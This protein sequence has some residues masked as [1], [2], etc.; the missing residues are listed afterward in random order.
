MAAWSCG[1]VQKG[2]EEKRSIL[3]KKVEIPQHADIPFNSRLSCTW[4]SGLGG[5]SYSFTF[6]LVDFIG[7]GASLDCASSG[8]RVL[9]MQ[10][11]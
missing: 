3:V 2:E 4:F 1:L 9:C 7:F 6:G 10:V 8:R 5:Q 11:M